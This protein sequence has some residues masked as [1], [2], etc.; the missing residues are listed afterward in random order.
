VDAH[1]RVSEIVTRN[2][3]EYMAMSENVDLVVD[4]E[5]INICKKFKCLGVILLY[6]P[7]SNEDTVG[8][9]FNVL[10]FKVFPR[11]MSSFNDLSV[12][13][14]YIPFNSCLSLLFRFTAP[15]RNLK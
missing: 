12:K 9:P 7:G 14:S 13:Y 4:H 2:K 5:K 15:K 3:H 8:P 11:L 1:G 10:H 6:S